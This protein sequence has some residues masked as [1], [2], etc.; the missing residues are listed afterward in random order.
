M[1]SLLKTFA[2]SNCI[3][4]VILGTVCDDCKGGAIFKILALVI[5]IM[6][7]GVGI[8][9]VIGISI[10]GIQYLTASGDAA[11]VQKA[12][13]RLFNIVIGLVAYSVLF[14]LLQFLIPGGVIRDWSENGDDACPEELTPTSPSGSGSGSGSGSSGQTLTTRPRACGPVT[15]GPL[16]EQKTVIL[17]GVSTPAY[18]A[19]NGRSYYIYNQEKGIWAD[20]KLNGGTSTVGQIGCNL[21]SYAT[22][23]N[24]FSTGMTYKPPVYAVDNAKTGNLADNRSGCTGSFSDKV[25]CVINKGGA[26]VANVCTGNDCPN[27]GHHF[28]PIVDW[29][30]SGG[31]IQYYLANTINGQGARKVGWVDAT[32][33]DPYICQPVGPRSCAVGYYGAEYYLPKDESLK[34]K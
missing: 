17:N 31:K 32:E 27:K 11:K 21:T 5:E 26:V 23:A 9:G 6:S 16:G 13:S 25:R 12:K 29:R 4:T 3:D 15:T 34:C 18:T 33:V 22:I 20:I 8:L 1:F 2:A 30:N 28:F 24:S 14:A 19:S 7:I 10:V